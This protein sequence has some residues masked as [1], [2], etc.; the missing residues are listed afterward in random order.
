MS[1]VI[2]SRVPDTLFGIVLGPA[3]KVTVGADHVQRLKAS[4]VS[5][6]SRNRVGNVITHTSAPNTERV[7]VQPWVG[8]SK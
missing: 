6:T 8:S 3:K 1:C 7:C 4:V 2:M 5:T